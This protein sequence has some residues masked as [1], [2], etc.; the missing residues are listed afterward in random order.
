LIGAV[1]GIIAAIFK[2]IFGWG[3]W[4]SSWHFDGPDMSAFTWFALLV[5]GVLIITRNGKNKR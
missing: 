3:D 4:H 5:I 1:F 2:A